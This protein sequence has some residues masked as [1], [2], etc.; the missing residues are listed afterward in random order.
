MAPRKTDLTVGASFEFTLLSNRWGHTDTYYLVRTPEGWDVQ[1]AGIGGACD[2]Q[3]RP[4]LF[5]N[6]RQDGIEYPESLGRRLEYLWEEAR[7][8]HMSQRQV[9]QALNSLAGW[10]RLAEWSIPGRQ[11]WAGFKRK[12]PRFGRL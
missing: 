6:L 9:Q 11:F 4:H 10:V 3:G 1:F 2:K 7:E 12:N 8:H 5:A